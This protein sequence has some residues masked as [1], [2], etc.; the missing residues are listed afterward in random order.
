MPGPDRPAVLVVCVHNAGR[1]QMAAGFLTTL[2][3]DIRARVEALSADLLAPDDQTP[4]SA[5]S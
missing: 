3:G 5:R 1:S 2:A 4:R